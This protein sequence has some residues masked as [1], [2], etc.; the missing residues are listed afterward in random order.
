MEKYNLKD[1]WEDINLTLQDIVDS[2]LH[3][4]SQL[5]LSKLGTSWTW[6]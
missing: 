2:G 4:G 6:S 5:N 3:I 1:V